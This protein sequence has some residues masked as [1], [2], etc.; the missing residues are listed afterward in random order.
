MTERSA[1]ANEFSATIRLGLPIVTVQ[2]ANMAL[3]FLDT[4]MAGRISPADLGA[5][6]AGRSLYTPIY[7]LALGI[8]LA[9]NP[10]VAQL[11][12]NEKPEQVGG[13]LKQ[14]IWL[15]ILCS[16][17]GVLLVRNT[18]GLLGILEVDPTLIPIVKGYLEA[19]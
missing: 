13:I 19:L 5:I 2:L 14:G 7:I 9:I 12:G 6:A 4:T 17:P 1:F 3:G 10:I 11:K 18:S 15:A 8:L 16:I